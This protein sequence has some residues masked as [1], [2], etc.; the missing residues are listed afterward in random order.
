MTLLNLSNI[1]EHLTLISSLPHLRHQLILRVLIDHFLWNHWIIQSSSVV[2]PSNTDGTLVKIWFYSNLLSCF[3]ISSK[4]NLLFCKH[5]YF[6]VSLH[7]LLVR[8][9]S[10][11]WDWC[12]KL[13]LHIKSLRAFLI[14]DVFFLILGSVKR[15]Q[16]LKLFHFLAKLSQVIYILSHRNK[17]AR[18]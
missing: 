7:D 17:S 15:F 12:V 10:S 16:V 5:C 3:W 4:L 11:F 2:Q 14:R 8:G 9:C 13:F 1:F 18:F 6:L